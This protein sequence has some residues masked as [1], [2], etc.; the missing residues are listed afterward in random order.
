MAWKSPPKASD[1][2]RLLQQTDEED[3]SS[4]GEPPRHSGSS[5]WL[6]LS[7]TL[8][9]TLVGALAIAPADDV[10]SYKTVVF[11][12]GIHL[13]KTEYQ[14][15]SDEVNVN[16][17]ALYNNMSLSLISPSS[18]SKLINKTTH[19]SGD[20]QSYVIQLAVFHNLHCLNMVRKLLYPS[21]YPSPIHLSHSQPHE[22]SQHEHSHSQ[23]SYEEEVIHLEHCIEGI[24][25]S[26]QCSADTSALFW[27]WSE[28]RQMMVGN[29]GTTHT[30]RD[31]EKVREWGL[32]HQT[33][34]YFDPYVKVEGA[35][36]RDD[37]IEFDD[38]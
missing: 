21:K 22:R 35:P 32:G 16:W 14:G 29:T 6:W 1:E 26:L 11:H 28:R 3:S 15:S 10:I 24:R 9:A 23:T 17:E 12:S 4:F 30:C 7:L 34:M 33:G 27:E 38:A 37:S 13:D 25:Q 20:P 19:L 8:N 2:E 36:V 5:I 31:W 18:A